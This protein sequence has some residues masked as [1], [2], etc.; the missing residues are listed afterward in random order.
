MAEE[1]INRIDIV[2]CIDV[3]CYSCKKLCAMSNTIQEE[4]RYYC[5]NCR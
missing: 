4:G 1:L 2:L 3:Y 5:C